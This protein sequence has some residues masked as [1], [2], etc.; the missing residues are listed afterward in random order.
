MRRF[1]KH[2]VW[3]VG[4]LV[5]LTRE[6]IID[7]KNFGPATA[8][9]IEAAL[10]RIRCRLATNFPHWPPPE[11]HELAATIAL[12][13]SPRAKCADDEVLHLV[14]AAGRP[15]NE[16]MVTRRYGWRGREP[17]TLR[18]IAERYSVHPNFVFQMC[19]RFEEH[20]EAAVVRMPILDAALMIVTAASPCT[21][22]DLEA[23]LTAYGLTKEIGIAGLLQA[24]RITGRRAAFMTTITTDGEVA[25]ALFDEE[26]YNAFWNRPAPL[27]SWCIPPRPTPVTYVR[28]SRDSFFATW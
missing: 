21:R 13:L 9:K 17:E 5:Q 18:A 11:L 23:R 8:D 19:K 3:Y 7:L 12:P 20:W 25:P 1:R 28:S 6:T 2:G 14:R 22:T 16:D 24:A 26:R 10:K 4:D 15:E 27:P